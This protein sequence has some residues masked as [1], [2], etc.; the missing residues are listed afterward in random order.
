MRRFNYKATDKDGKVVKGSVQADSEKSAGKLLI[1]QGYVPQKI[2]EE[3]DGGALGKFKD[4]ITGKDKRVFTRQFA[5]LIGAGLPMANALRIVADQTDRRG[6]KAVIED[7]LAQIEAGK[8]LELACRAHPEVFDN[9]YLALIGA[10]EMSG[11]LDESLKRLAN[12]QEKDEEMLSKIR[13]AL[14]YPAIVLV[15]IIFVVVFMLVEVVPQVEALY[16]DLGE[17]LPTLTQILVNVANFIMNEWWII[18]IVLGILIFFLL[19]FRK[20]A[21]GYRWGSIIKLNVPLFGALFHRLYSARFA[22]TAQTLLSAGVSML[23][24]MTISA[25]AM[26]N[27]IMKEG[28]TEAEKL[29][30][31]G[32]PLSTALEK[33]DYMLPL[34]PQMAAIGEESGRIDEMLGKAAKVYEDELDERI[35]TI[36]TLIEPVLMVILA[37]VAMGMVG[38][39]LFPIYNLVNSIG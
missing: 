34:V 22:R 38:A 28:I 1:D 32:K 31:A 6:M 13:G 17:E 3:G 2:T 27:E 11:T 33:V 12:Q 35:R 39:I 7:L 8:T 4:R 26:N 25:D 16:N 19:T 5:T 10:G 20:T 18:L 14:T 24:T 37:I 21:T 15:V 29:V 36:S 23:D 30:R 9:V